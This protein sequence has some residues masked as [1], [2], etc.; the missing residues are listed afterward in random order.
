MVNLSVY[1]LQFKVLSKLLSMG[2]LAPFAYDGGPS[3]AAAFVD[4]VTPDDYNRAPKAPA[5]KACM[6]RM[7]ARHFAFTAVSWLWPPVLAVTTKQPR[8]GGG[9]R[10]RWALPVSVF[11]PSVGK[12]RQLEVSRALWR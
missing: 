10:T 9:G 7:I 11:R 12:N 4:L 6:H 1:E 3:R 5:Q 8:R 2:A